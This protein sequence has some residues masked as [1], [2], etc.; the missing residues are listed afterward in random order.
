MK[1][2]SGKA[3]QAVC[4][5]VP[6]PGAGKRAAR[7]GRSGG[8][9]AASPGRP[10]GRGTRRALFGARKD[11]AQDA[12]PARGAFAGRDVGPLAGR[13]PGRTLADG[14]RTAGRPRIILAVRRRR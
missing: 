13:A 10:G 4:P 1:I 3:A 9:D 11:A 14:G 6:R 7:T 12:G 2:Y 5:L 8:R